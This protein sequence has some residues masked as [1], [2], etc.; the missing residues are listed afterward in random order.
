MSPNIPGLK[1]Q[2]IPGD[3]HCL[4]HAVGLYVNQDQASL[5]KSV[6]DYINRNMN[7]LRGFIQLQEGQTIEDYLRAV[8]EGKEWADHIEIDVNKE[9]NIV[10][11]LLCKIRY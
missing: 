10:A 4:F 3:G 8:K 6:A 11:Y 9:L 1:F 2:K 5:R 7:T